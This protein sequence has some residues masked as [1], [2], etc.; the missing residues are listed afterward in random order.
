MTLFLFPLVPEQASTLAEHTD[1]L[2]SFLLAVSAF[3]A[4]LIFLLVLYFAVKYRRRSPVERP[5]PIFG[6]LLLELVWTLIP[7]GLTM[8]MFIW[9]TSLYVTAYRPPAGALEVFVVGKQWMWKL[10]H[11]EGQR[12]ID[13]L[14]IPMGRPIRLTMTS[15]DVI[16]SFFI[17]AFRIKKDVL[18]GRYTTIWFEATK[19]GEYHLFCT[20]YCGTNHAAMIGR[21]VVMKPVDYERWL[22]GAAGESMVSAGERLFQAEGCIGCHRLDGTGPAPSLVGV[23]GKPVQLQGGETVTADADYIRESILSPMAKI[24][25]GYQPIMPTFQGRLSEEQLL[26]LIA[27]IKSLG[28]QEQVKATR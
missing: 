19:P 28:K 18:P 8:I 11:P 20:Q 9:G 7:L 21:V 25:A 10:Q 27:Y 22:G 13:E 24:V 26:R 1:T 16:H 23:F 17:P 15:E 12:E 5:R 14:H 3:F 6:N 2:F 4:G